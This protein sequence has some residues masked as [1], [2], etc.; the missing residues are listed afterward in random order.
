M[1]EHPTN[2]QTGFGDN[3][4]SAREKGIAAIEFAIIFP[5]LLLILFGVVQYSWLLNNYTRV[6]NAAGIGVTF[7]STR[8]QSSKPPYRISL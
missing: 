3:M 8:W 6:I 5:F 4:V 2:K 1:I 7:F